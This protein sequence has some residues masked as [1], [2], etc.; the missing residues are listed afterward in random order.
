MTPALKSAKVLFVTV[1]PKGD[2]HIPSVWRYGVDDSLLLYQVI[3]Y[4]SH[5]TPD[6][7]TIS[8]QRNTK[9]QNDTGQQARYNHTSSITQ[10]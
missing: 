3:S 5:L 8:P 9:K 1:A 10:R 6:T 4:Q 2:W 7:D